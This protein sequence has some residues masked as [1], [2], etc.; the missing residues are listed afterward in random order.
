MLAIFWGILSHGVGKGSEPE[1]IKCWVRIRVGFC[2]RSAAKSVRVV[3]Q[4]RTFLLPLPRNFVIGN[5]NQEISVPT[6]AF[7]KGGQSRDIWD[8]LYEKS[9]G[10]YKIGSRRMV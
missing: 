10:I 1:Y 2:K 3:R 9:T 7:R 6:E 4:R 8:C 5:A